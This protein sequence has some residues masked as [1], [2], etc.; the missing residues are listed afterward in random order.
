M[1]ANR[2]IGEIFSLSSKRV[3]TITNSWKKHP[4]QPTQETSDKKGLRTPQYGAFSAVSAHWSISKSAATISMPTGTGK[5]D[6]MIAIMLGHCCEKT[7]IVVPS[8]ALRTQISEKFS[9]LGILRELGLIHH[10]VENPSVGVLQ[11]KPKTQIDFRNFIKKCNVI[12]ATQQVLNWIDPQVIS[13]LST[14]VT[15][16][17]FDEAH[18]IPAKKWTE[19]KELFHKSKILQF[20]ATPFRNDKKR[21]EGELIYN[22]PLN[23]AQD[24]GYFKPVNKVEV[25]ELNKD[26]HDLR[27][28]YKALEI[29]ERDKNNGHPHVMMVRVSSISRSHEIY[30]LYTKIITELSLDFQVV[31]VHSKIPQQKDVYT[32]ILNLEYDIVVCVDMFGE[33]FDLPQFKICA[34]HDLK[35]SLPTTLQFIGR[36]T[37][38]SNSLNLGEASI[39]VNAADVRFTE[40]IK[41]LYML[42]ADWNSLLHSLSSEQI[43]E[44]VVSQELSNIFTDPD[45]VI[46][47]RSIKPSFSVVAYKIDSNPVTCSLEKVS[48]GIRNWDK[49]PYRRKFIDKNTRNTIV[50][51][52]GEYVG[53]KSLR[54][55]EFDSIEYTLYI[56]YFDSKNNILYI[57]SS[58]NNGVYSTIA[59]AVLEGNYHL[60]NG[61]SAFRACSGIKMMSIVN[62]GYKDRLDRRRSFTMVAGQ[63]V[64][65]AIRKS[66]NNNGQKC[67]F[68][69]TGY[70]EGNK[71]SIGCSTKGRIWSYQS[72]DIKEFTEWASRLSG[73]LLNESAAIEQI[74]KDATDIKVLE[75]YSEI[76]NDVLYVDW[77]DDIDDLF[78]TKTTLVLP[79]GTLIQQLECNLEFL[80][81]NEE[82]LSFKILWDNQETDCIVKAEITQNGSVNY[83]CSHNIVFQRKNRNF[84]TNEYFRECPP[85]IICK[86][87]DSVIGANRYRYT[88]E[89]TV[90]DSNNILVEGWDGVDIRSE[91]IGFG[92]NRNEESIQY[93]MIEKLRQGNYFEKQFDLIINDDGA[94][95]AADIVAFTINQQSITMSLFHLK[96]SHGDNPGHRVSDLYEVCGQAAKSFSWANPKTKMNVI[97]H[98]RKRCGDKPERFEK[99]DEG[100]LVKIHQM[101]MLGCVLNTNIYIAQPGLSKSRVSDQQ[102]AILESTEQFLQSTFGLELTVIGSE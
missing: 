19:L 69:C 48:S 31:K 56:V 92:K 93:Y 91:S 59:D 29:L 40:E 53:N 14:V 51:I 6:T 60:I 98:L 8:D 78:K 87:F 83:V 57:N 20:T 82:E 12:V 75:S 21:I 84:T 9:T 28:A 44:E 70:R 2:T 80:Q 37:R 47:A 32:S 71:L 54:Q 27:I 43:N 41:D 24:E 45:G 88:F 35:Q 67:N 25:F 89:N 100:T 46:D 15:H 76:A 38:E 72:G 65:D 55:C 66:E 101:A 81:V 39:V 77:D 102:R 85:Y 23:I 17:F 64:T 33:G 18:H 7:L 97:N 62:M 42:D 11:S 79:S 13:E 10:S 4:F 3:K 26:K 50:A 1:A 96:Y 58:G 68:F 94:G 63:D 74:F 49:F 90:F 30:N 34:Y 16:V 61:H 73:Y 99:G 36:F 22:F 95:E 86:D 52:T 5:T